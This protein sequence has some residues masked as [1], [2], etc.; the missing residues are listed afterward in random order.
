VK[1]LAKY[2]TF[3]SGTEKR[4]NHIGMHKDTWLSY[5]MSR[6][7]LFLAPARENSPSQWK[8]ESG[9]IKRGKLRLEWIEEG[10]SREVDT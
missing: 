6:V 9:M 5:E 3:F 7:F 1:Y 10:A 4:D 2:I 8:R